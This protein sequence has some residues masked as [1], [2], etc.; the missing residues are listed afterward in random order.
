MEPKLKPAQR[1][2][3]KYTCLISPGERNKWVLEKTSSN[4]IMKADGAPV[5]VGQQHC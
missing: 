4:D 1:T 5:A 2:T 3:E